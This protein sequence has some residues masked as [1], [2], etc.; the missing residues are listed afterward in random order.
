M[1]MGWPETEYSPKMALSV[2]LSHPLCSSYDMTGTPPSPHPKTQDLGFLPLTWCWERLTAQWSR[3]SGQSDA[4]TFL[5]LG[6]NKDTAS[7]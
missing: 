4:I 7:A 1:A 5:R 2:Y 6:H 3:R